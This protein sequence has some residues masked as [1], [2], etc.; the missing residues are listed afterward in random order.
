MGVLYSDFVIENEYQNKQNTV[1]TGEV[2]V[3]SFAGFLLEPNE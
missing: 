2:A 1:N 3:Q